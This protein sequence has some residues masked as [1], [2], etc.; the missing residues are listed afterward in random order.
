M[1]RNSTFRNLAW[2][3]SFLLVISALFNGFFVFQ[4]LMIHSDLD[5]LKS[6]T[7]LF[8][9]LQATAQNLMNDLIGYGQK[10]PGIYPILQKYGFNPPQPPSAPPPI[11]P[12]PS[13]PT[14][15]RR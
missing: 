8:P 9:Q 6:K 7:N 5:S 13:A 12:P 4:H 11:P 15:K 3:V 2:L 14:P 1:N 10:Q